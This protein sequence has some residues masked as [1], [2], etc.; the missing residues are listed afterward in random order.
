MN[1][2]YLH[3]YV[4]YS[5]KI[6][7]IY[8]TLGEEGLGRKGTYTLYAHTIYDNRYLI[9]SAVLPCCIVNNDNTVIWGKFV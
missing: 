7:T 4:N 6:A 5:R 9:L 1:D 2:K 8:K 3:M